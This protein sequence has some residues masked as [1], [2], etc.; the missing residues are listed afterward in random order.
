MQ[1]QKN[2]SI[3]QFNTFGVDVKANLFVELKNENFL[4]ELFS[5]VNEIPNRFI[6]GGGSNVL[7]TKDFNGIIIKNLLPGIEKIGEDNNFVFIK[8]GAGVNWHKL[9]KYSIK[10]NYWGIENLSLIPGTVGAA[11]IQNIGAYGQ[12]LKNVFHQL[13]T[14]DLQNNQFKTFAKDECKFGYR[15]SIFKKEFKNRF[16]ITSVTLKLS[17]KE[18]AILTYQPVKEEIDRLKINKPSISQISEIICNIRRS[19]LPDPNKLGNAGSFFKNPEIT[20]K[21]YLELKKANNDIKGFKTENNKY[22]I[23]AGWLIEKCGW[24]GKRVG[25]VSSFEK[26]ALVLVNVGKATGKDILDFAE[27]IK[28]IV[29]V[30][31]GIELKE[32]INIV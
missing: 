13:E 20:E 23:S 10:N 26:Q 24:K 16:L 9:V 2:I 11:P 27:S 6:L 25:D 5:S 19:K 17:K 22:K 28:E 7:F 29:K 3:K 21:K 15:D 31:F 4:N 1:I 14:F 30:K 32:E 12:E 18:D 8:T